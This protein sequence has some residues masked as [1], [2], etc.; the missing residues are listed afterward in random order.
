LLLL[1]RAYQQ[2]YPDPHQAIQDIHAA[3]DLDY[4]C[5]DLPQL[6]TSM[7]NGVKRITTIVN[8]LCAFSRL[9]ESDWKE[10][11]LRESIQS[12]IAILNQRLKQAYGQPIAVHWIGEQL[13]RIECYASQMNQV[14]MNLLNNAIDALAESSNNQSQPLD[15]TPLRNSTLQLDEQDLLKNQTVPTLWICTEVDEP[16][17]LSIR[18]IDNG[19]G[20]APGILPKIF[21]PFFTTKPVGQGIGMGLATS[22]QIITKLH[23]GDLDCRSR[24]G[25]GTVFT[26]TLRY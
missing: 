16:G 8:A 18:M 26:I 20:I 17:M 22:H 15:I 9:G 24:V 11:D 6:T 5:Q 4:I 7:N 21:D 14:M 1:I 25:I 13:P 12:T 10:I 23:Q 19:I 2:Y 3:V